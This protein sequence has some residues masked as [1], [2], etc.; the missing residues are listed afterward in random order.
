V[1]VNVIRHRREPQPRSLAARLTTAGSGVAVI[2]TVSWAVLFFALV[3]FAEVPDAVIRVVQVVQA[4]AFAALVPATIWV[5]EGF[6]RRA[7]WLRITGRVLVLLALGRIASFAIVFH[8][9]APDISY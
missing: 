8:L 4:L 7:G 3:G 5:V 1:L 2:A 9:L 6:R